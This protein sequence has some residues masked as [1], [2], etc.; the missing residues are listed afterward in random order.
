MNIVASKDLFLKNFSSLA[1][2]EVV[3]SHVSQHT[4]RGVDGAGYD[5]TLRD[6]DQLVSLIENK[7]VAGSYRFSPYREKLI[8]KGAESLP[9]KVS[10]PTIRDRI[11][12]RCLNNFLCQVFPDCKPPHAHP[13]VSK[14]IRSFAE[15]SSADAFIKIDVRSFYDHIDH[16]ILLCQ[17]RKRIKFEPALILVSGAISTATGARVLDKKCNPLGV[18]QGLSISNILASIYML[19]IDLE[20]GSR[21]D[22]DYVRYVDDILLRTNSREAG[23]IAGQFSKKLKRS[24]KLSTHPMGSGKTSISQ[25]GESVSYLGYAFQAK[26]VSVREASVKKMMTSLMRIIAGIN[27]NN[28]EKSIWRLNLRVS[29]CRIQGANVGWLFY[30]S[31]I[32]DHKVLV[33]LDRQIKSRLSEVKRPDLYRQCKNF[34]K[35]HREIRTNFKGTPYVFDFDAF[36]RAQM[37]DAIYLIK[38]DSKGKLDRKT[39][40]EVKSIFF[41]TMYREA[42]DMERDTLGSFS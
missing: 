15:A 12:L 35:A 17:L 24:R 18:P 38:P 8:L 7:A 14:A 6:L 25:F 5:V 11:T 1:I 9:R 29:G 33:R 10:I 16:K 37:L 19:A 2:R 41:Q 21:L 32:N 3:E 30:F 13:I 36:S 22:I 20:Y 4:A 28:V 40:R 31:Q 39:D 34:V 42:K 27:D 26:S 23:L